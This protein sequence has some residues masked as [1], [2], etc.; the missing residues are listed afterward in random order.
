[1]FLKVGDGTSPRWYDYL[2]QNHDLNSSNNTHLRHRPLRET[3]SRHHSKSHVHRR[4]WLWWWHHWTRNGHVSMRSCLR[5][6]IKHWT[7]NLKKYLN[8]SESHVNR[9]IWLWRRHHW[10]R[11]VHVSMRSRLRVKIEDWT[12]KLK[13]NLKCGQP[14]FLPSGLSTQHLKRR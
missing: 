14:P 11:N 9:Q 6:K 5:V 7:L 10:T 2:D 3:M 13:N 4:R 1:M 8:H 12:L